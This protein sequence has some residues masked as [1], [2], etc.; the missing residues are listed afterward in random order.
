[1]EPHSETRKCW[2]VVTSAGASALYVGM[3]YLEPLVL[4]N[5]AENRKT[6]EAALPS[7]KYRYGSQ[8]QNFPRLQFA[9]GTKTDLKDFPDHISKK[10]PVP[11][12]SEMHDLMM[13]I[14]QINSSCHTPEKFCG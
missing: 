5:A 12:P 6:T 2:L 1:M 14:S 11:A 9:K 8:F 13:G 7:G 3:K 4:Y 10:L